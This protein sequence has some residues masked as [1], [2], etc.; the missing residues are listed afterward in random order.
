MFCVCVCVPSP[1]SCW[2]LITSVSLCLQS[3]RSQEQAEAARIEA[4]GS[5]ED[6]EELKRTRAFD[7]YKDTHRQGYGNSKLKPCG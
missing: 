6:E 1:G 7:D 3:Q 2:E 4:L 5:D